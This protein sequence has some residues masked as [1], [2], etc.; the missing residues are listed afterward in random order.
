MLVTGDSAAEYEFHGFKFR[1]LA[2]PS[3]GSTEIAMWTIDVPEGADSAPHTVDKEEVFYV[4]SGSVEIQGHVAGPGDV[5][6]VAPHT[7]L[8]V[9][10]GPAHVIVATSVGVSGVLNGERIQGPWSL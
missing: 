7:E 4:Q 2:V 8:A 1:S 6:V 3:R 9:R 10:G 5:V